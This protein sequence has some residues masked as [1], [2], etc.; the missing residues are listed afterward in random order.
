MKMYYDKVKNNSTTLDDK[1]DKEFQRMVSLQFEVVTQ[2][3]QQKFIQ[4]AK[5]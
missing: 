3:C 2:D 4:E 5:P 1:F